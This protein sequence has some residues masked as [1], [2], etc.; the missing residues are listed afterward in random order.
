[1]KRIVAMLLVLVM[2]SLL[3]TAAVSAEPEQE[4]QVTIFL[5]RHGKTLFNTEHRVQGWC[6]TPLTE[7]GIAVA[8]NLGLGLKDAGITFDAAY[9]S[10]LGR[11]RDTARLVL[12]NLGLTDMEVRENRNLRETCFGSWEGELE[13]VRDAAYCEI[14]GTESVY[15]I[16]PQG[17]LFQDITVQ[18]DTTGLAESLETAQTRFL[19]ALNEIAETAIANGEK[20]VLVVSSGG[21]IN[22]I[23]PLLGGEGAEL[24]NASVTMLY[25]NNGEFTLGVVGDMSYA[26][27]GAELR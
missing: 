9:S 5:T 7:D 16:Y 13:S 26:D 2:A 8:E 22:T 1:M 24:K 10:D 23:I 15:E 11:Q 19:A 20:N 18:T 17:S 3:L 21:I 12:D 14:A 25:Y 4:A 6:D 27:R